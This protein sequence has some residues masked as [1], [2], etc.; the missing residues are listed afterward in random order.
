MLELSAAEAR[1]L[2]L[3]AQGLLGAPD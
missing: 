2:V 1:R 3:R